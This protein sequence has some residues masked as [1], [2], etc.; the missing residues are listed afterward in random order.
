MKNNEKIIYKK[1]RKII[2]NKFN[3]EINSTNTII[4]S[5]LSS[6]DRI[7]FFIL[8]EDEFNVSYD[9]EKPLIT[10]SDVID[11]ITSYKERNHE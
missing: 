7:T 3:V 2:N 11:F 9:F 5:E 1:I 4:A 10:I 6:L 8:I